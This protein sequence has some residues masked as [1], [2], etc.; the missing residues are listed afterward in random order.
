[1]IPKKIHYCW[2]GNPEKPESV[3]RTM[4]TWKNVGRD[5]LLCEWNE[6]NCD[7]DCCEYVRGAAQRKKW[8]LL[9]DYFRLAALER[10]GG[11][12]LDTDAVCYKSFDDL[13]DLHGFLGYMYDSLIGTAVMGF[14]AH[15]PFVRALLS[16]YETAVWID[17]RRFEITLPGGGKHVC[18]CNNTVFTWLILEFY[19]DFKLHGR[20]IDLPELTVF[21]MRE[22]EVG[23][24]LGR[25][26]SVH[27]CQASWKNLS[28]KQKVFQRLKQFGARLPLVHLDALLRGLSY[29]RHIRA[30]TYYD[31]YKKDGGRV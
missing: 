2:Y 18:N 19:P 16:V 6:T 26:H 28:A 25:G 9:S 22:F 27:L 30:S 20:R 3:R 14:E 10:E 23:R 29:R 24:V 8:A 12:Y 1:M 11:I 4:Q 31:R 7:F 5:Y 15:H 17:D 21:P 13:L